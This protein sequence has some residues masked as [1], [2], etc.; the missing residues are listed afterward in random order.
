M[1]YLKLL[2]NIFL[3]FLFIFFLTNFAQAKCNFGI[4]IG[5]NI[6][7]LKNELAEEFIEESIIDENI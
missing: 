3:S 4:N 7:N 5:D 1:I 6:S 2:K